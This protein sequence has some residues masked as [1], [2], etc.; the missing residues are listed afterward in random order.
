M[1]PQ[2][3]YNQNG[4]GSFWSGYGYDQGGGGAGQPAPAAGKGAGGAGG[5]VRGGTGASEPPLPMTIRNQQV[6]IS[7]FFISGFLALVTC[8]NGLKRSPNSETGL[9]TPDQL[10]SQS[11]VPTEDDALKDS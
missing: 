4:G 6:C 10:R 11:D 2:G 1:D 7:L 5:G 3:R 8:K 9:S